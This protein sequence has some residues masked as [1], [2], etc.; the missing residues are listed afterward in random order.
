MEE[1]GEENE[2]EESDEEEDEESESEYSD[3]E[4]DMAHTNSGFVS[5]VLGNYAGMLASRK[6]A[7]R[8]LEEKLNE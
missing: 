7:N 8:Q 3:E 4:D 1:P 5:K 2:T 6:E